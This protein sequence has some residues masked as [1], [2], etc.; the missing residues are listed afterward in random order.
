MINRKKGL[1]YSGE[2][3]ERE[4]KPEPEPHPPSKH[5]QIRGTSPLIL[6]TL[7]KRRIITKLTSVKLLT[8]K[9]LFYC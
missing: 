4:R 3:E 5:G 9:L 7:F 6:A 8:R 2:D 1:P